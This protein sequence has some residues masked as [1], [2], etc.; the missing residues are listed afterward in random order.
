MNGPPNQPGRRPKSVVLQLLN[1]WTASPR[2]NRGVEASSTGQ[3][4]RH[5]WGRPLQKGEYRNKAFVHPDRTRQVAPER[6]PQRDLWAPCYPEKPRGEHIPARFLLAYRGIRH[7]PD[8]ENM[9]RMSVLCAIYPSTRTGQ[10]NHPHHLAI[11]R[12]GARSGR[13]SQKGT[14]GLHTS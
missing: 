11:F 2:Q 7:T 12:L 10:P 9:R 8:G 4:L 1:Q 13:T 14:R 6:H 5:D 3:V